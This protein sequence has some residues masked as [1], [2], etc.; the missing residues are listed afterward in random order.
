MNI[1]A[2][3][4]LPETVEDILQDMPEVDKAIVM[5]TQAGDLTGFHLGWDKGIWNKY[6]L[7]Y[8]CEFL[9]KYN[10]KQKFTMY[11][12]EAAEDYGPCGICYPWQ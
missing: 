3:P 6:N 11:L 2:P 1:T 9:R 10:V 4:A 8:D 12:G 5:D 7:T